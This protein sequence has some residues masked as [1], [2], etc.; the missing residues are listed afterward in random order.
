MSSERF[1]GKVLAPLGGKPIIARVIA[2]VTQVIPSEMVVVA[3]SQEESDDPLAYYL[4]GNGIQ[5]FRG[6]LDN[7]FSRFQLCL[8]EFPCT[9]FFRIC[10]DSPFLDSSLM[11]KIMNYCDR[12]QVDLVTNVFPR[13]FPP[14]RSLE[15]VNSKPFAAI[16]SA[17]LTKE[18]QEHLT[19][20]YYNHSD[21][22]KIINLESGNPAL[23]K[24]SFS[25]DTIE[26]LKRLERVL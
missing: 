15:M 18:E 3:T 20:V 26:D 9:W 1:P 17:N 5:V 6:P 21:R 13:T 11:Q 4:R 12:T 8:R 16:D 25:V 24:E 7:V 19:Q 23:A 10:A 14:G 2:R 22:F